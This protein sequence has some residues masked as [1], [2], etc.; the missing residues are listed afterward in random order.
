MYRKKCFYFD[1]G[2]GCHRGE[3]CEYLHVENRMEKGNDIEDKV[4]REKKS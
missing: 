2:K 4:M 1:T 3:D